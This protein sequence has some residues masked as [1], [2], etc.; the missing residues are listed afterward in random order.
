VSIL[1]GRKV[2]VLTYQK[3]LKHLLQLRKTTQNQKNWLAK[4]LGYDFDIIYWP[5]PGQENWATDALS[6]MEEGELIALIG[7]ILLAAENI[8]Q[9]MNVD[10]HLSKIITSF[11]EKT[12]EKPGY[13]LDQECL[14]YKGRIVITA[15]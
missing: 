4:P 13:S 10:P 6:Q 3:I 9:A 11:Q 2:T 5:R 12:N 8:Q 1:R 15:N 7:P 14:F